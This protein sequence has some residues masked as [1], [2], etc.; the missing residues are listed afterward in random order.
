MG[1][2]FAGSETNSVARDPGG[3]DFQIAA[4]SE[5][6]ECVLSVP[7]PGMGRRRAGR[8]PVV[9]F[10]KTMPRA[11]SC[12]ENDVIEQCGTDLLFRVL[13]PGYGRNGNKRLG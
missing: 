8:T 6:E 3:D 13:T 7:R 9:L 4:R 2:G 10:T 11:R 5:R 1:G 12:S